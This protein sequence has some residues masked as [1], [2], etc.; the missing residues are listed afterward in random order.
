MRIT[1]WD[2]DF[3]HK[4]SFKPNI[5]VMKLSSF[6]KQQQHIINF[7]NDQEDTRYDFDMMYIVKE[8]E[9]TPFPPSYLIDHKNVRLIG[10]EFKI[11]P[12]YFETNMIIDM[13][14]PDYKLYNLPENNIYSSSNMLQLLHGNKKLPVRQNEENIQSGR[15]LNIITDKKLWQTD[16]ATLIEILDELLNYNNIFFEHPVELK[17][18]L[19][20]DTVKEKFSKL[21]FA[22]A[23]NQPFRNNYGHE[24]IDAKQIIDLFKDIKTNLPHVRLGVISFKTV[25]YEHWQKLDTGIQDLE[26]CLQ[27]IDYAKAN[28]ITIRFRSSNNRLITPFWPFFEVL[29]IWTEYH[30]YKSFIQVMLEPARRR[31][32]LKWYDILNNPKKWYS[33]RAEFLLHLITTYPSIIKQYGLRMWGE[34]ILS[35]NEIDIEQISKYAFIFD[36]EDMKIKLQKE[37]IGDEAAVPGYR[38]NR[39]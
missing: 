24:F 38:D 13:V 21:R 37:L 31:Q 8:H 34:N 18:I 7:V 36:Q 22:A 27:I 9:R 28:K 2:M 14:R 6:H 33:P 20:N 23:V 25:I 1:I 26:R 35:L 5:T 12:N 29:D 19:T 10:K 17:P 30:K 4:L 32:K 15:T 11:Y 16:T 3:F 39:L